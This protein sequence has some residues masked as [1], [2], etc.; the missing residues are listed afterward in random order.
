VEVQS[1]DSPHRPR[2]SS[3]PAAAR[4]SCQSQTHV[5]VDTLMTSTNFENDWTRSRAAWTILQRSPRRK[6][7]A[8][9]ARSSQGGIPVRRVR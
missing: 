7:W 5:T 8:A 3:A 9:G 6:T 4:N 2:L 1:L